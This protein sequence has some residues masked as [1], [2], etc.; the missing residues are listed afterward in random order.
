[1][2][3][4]SKIAKENGWF[5]RRNKTPDAHF[6]ATSGRSRRDVKARKRAEAEARNAVAEAKPRLCGHVHGL[7]GQVCP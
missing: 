2:Y 6:A 1:M 7:T 3:G 4:T 5:S